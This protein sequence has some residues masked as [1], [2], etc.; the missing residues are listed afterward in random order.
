MATYVFLVWH[1]F[2]FLYLCKYLWTLYTYVYNACEVLSCQSQIFISVS[3]IVLSHP[4]SLK[5]YMFGSHIC[6][7]FFFLKIPMNFLLQFKNISHL[8]AIFVLSH[9]WPLTYSLFGRHIS[10]SLF[11]QISFESVQAWVHIQN[12]SAHEVLSWQPKV[13]YICTPY[14]SF[15]IYDPF[16][17]PCLAIIFALKNAYD[18]F[19]AIH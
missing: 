18:I 17:I 11:M 7:V 14:L 15:H 2:C 8:S 19:T 6:L 16:S 12:A 10:F 9:L 3:H 1:I 13:F 4:W 5:Y